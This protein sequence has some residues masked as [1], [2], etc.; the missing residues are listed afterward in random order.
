MFA[1][2]NRKKED[3]IAQQRQRQQQQHQQQQP[4]TYLTYRLVYL[5]LSII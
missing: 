4:E 1:V 5:D 2:L 3:E